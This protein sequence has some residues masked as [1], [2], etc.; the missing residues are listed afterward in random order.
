[1]VLLPLHLFLSREKWQGAL[2]DMRR[3][4]V[5]LV[6]ESLRLARSVA[7]KKEAAP[8]KRAPPK[9]AELEG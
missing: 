1:L 7:A 5:F 9:G 2:Y 6:D 8:E 3:E 4:T